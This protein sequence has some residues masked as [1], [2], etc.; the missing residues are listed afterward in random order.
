MAMFSFSKHFIL[1]A[2]LMC[3]HPS[4]FHIKVGGINFDLTDP[5]RWKSILINHIFYGM[6]NWI[7]YITSIEVTHKKFGPVPIY[8]VHII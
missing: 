3:M 8:W 7:V 5:K 2:P 4:N 6:T 1:Y